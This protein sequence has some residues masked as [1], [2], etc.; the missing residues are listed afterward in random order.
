MA[1][2]VNVPYLD[3]TRLHPFAWGRRH[4]LLTIDQTLAAPGV[5]LLVLRL[6]LST[7]VVAP[8]TLEDEPLRSGCAKGTDC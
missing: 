3:F 8:V 5:R 4:R 2:F 6:H 7:G 1:G